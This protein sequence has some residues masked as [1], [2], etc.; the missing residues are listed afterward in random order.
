MMGIKY[1]AHRHQAVLTVWALAVSAILPVSTNSW[2]GA[3][4]EQQ[5]QESA[6][7]L[8]A[9]VEQTE[10]TFEAQA[11]IDG[12]FSESSDAMEQGQR[13]LPA[14]RI[15]GVNVL[16][17]RTLVF[18]MGRD[19][20]YL[21]RLKRQCFGLRKDTPI[22]YE[23]H[24]SQFCKHD[25][26]RA[27]ETWSTNQLVPGPRCSI[28][29]FIPLTDTEK[30]LVKARVKA[31]RDAKIAERKAEK[32]ARRAAKETAKA[33]SLSDPSGERRQDGENA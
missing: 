26:F 23:V 13:C 4:G 9:T 20:N 29:A 32:A 16:D 6:Q 21:V 24:G 8:A 14:R 3:T 5:G 25:G 33:A 17:N 10:A 28:P 12:I 30:E 1:Q 15:R 27:L 2:A 11:R 31:D 22:S 7:D 19:E 18:D